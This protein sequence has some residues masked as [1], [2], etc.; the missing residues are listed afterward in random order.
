MHKNRLDKMEKMRYY[1][2]EYGRIL[3]ICGSV[4]KGA[5]KHDGGRKE[6]FPLSTVRTVLCAEKN[7]K[8]RG[9]Q[10]NKRKWLSA[11]LALCMI[12]GMVPFTFSA[13]ADETGSAEYYVMYGGTG[14]GLT[15]ENP[16][17]SL[18]SAINAI[19]NSGLGA[20]T[21]YVIDAEDAFTATVGENKVAHHFVSY[22]IYSDKVRYTATVT[23]KGA[24][25]MANSHIALSP[26]WG[27]N[28]ET[29]LGGPTVFEDITIFR[30]RGSDNGINANGYALTIGENVSFQKTKTDLA[31]ASAKWDGTLMDT[32]L[33]IKPGANYPSGIVE[34]GAGDVVVINSNTEGMENRVDLPA[35]SD[36]RTYANDTTIYVNKAD[37]GIKFNVGGKNK[38]GTSAVYSKNLNLVFGNIGAVQVV[39]ADNGNI[40]DV[41]KVKGGFQVIIPASVSY[42]DTTD[43]Y[44]TADGGKWLMKTEGA[45]VLDVTET[46]GAFSVASGTVYAYNG[47]NKV[48]YNTAST[49]TVPAGEWNVTADK[50][51]ATANLPAGTAKWVD[52]G[53]GTLTAQPDK[54]LNELYVMYGGTGDG[55]T[56]ET[57]LGSIA[58]AIATINV[59]G[60][61]TGTIYVIDAEDAFT[62]T[63]GEN[64]VAHHFVSWPT[65]DK[66]V[67]HTAVITVKG[68]DGMEGS[69]LA[70][71]PKWGDNSEAYLGGPTVFE[72][73][74]LFRT[75]YYDKSFNANGY[76]MTYG[77][78][79]AFAGPTKDLVNADNKWDGTL[80]P[81]SY[82]IILGANY[83][84]SSLKHGKGGTVTI[85]AASAG[86]TDPTTVDLPAWSDGR[87]YDSL[88]LVVKSEKNGVKI[89][90]G[91]KYK[92]TS[93]V[94]NGNVNIV[95]TDTPAINIVKAASDITDTV[96]IKGGFQVIAPEATTVTNTA[97]SYLTADAGMWYIKT[98]D[99]IT[100]NKTETAGTFTS[101]AVVYAYREGGTTIYYGTTLTL[102]AGEW[103]VVSTLD[104]AKAGN[105]TPDAPSPLQNFKDWKD[106]GNGKVTAV[107]ETQAVNGIYYVMYGGT[108]D[109]TT[110]EKPMGSI[111]AAVAA[112]EADI[113]IDEGTVY[114]TNNPAYA[115]NYLPAGEKYHKY[116]TWTQPAAHEKL[117]HVIGTEAN[118]SSVIASTNCGTA[119]DIVLA[120]PTHFSNIT[121]TRMRSV[122]EGM[123]TAGFDVTIDD[124]V[125][126]MGTNKDFYGQ[127]IPSGTSL[128]SA[129]NNKFIKFGSGRGDAA[130][131]GG[132]TEIHAKEAIYMESDWKG[133]TYTDD[134]T[135]A[136]ETSGNSFEMLMA[137]NTDKHSNYKKNLNFVFGNVSAVTLKGNNGTATVAKDFQVI[138]PQ[139]VSVTLPS[140]VTVLGDTYDLA[141]ETNGLIDVTDV[142]GVYNVI[143]DG[144]VIATDV[145]DSAVTY[146]SDNGVLTV[147]AGSYI[148]KAFTDDSKIVTAIFD[149]NYATV[150]GLRGQSILLP[151]LEDRLLE[152]FKGWKLDDSDT[153]YAGGTKYPLTDETPEELYFTSVWGLHE[154][155]AAV[156]VDAAN[157][158]DNND[159]SSAS[160]AFAT[161]NAGFAALNAKTESTK[162][163]VIV[164]NYGFT[165]SL[166]KNDSEIIIM[167]DGSGNSVFDMISDYIEA[168]GPVA[169]ENIV[170]QSST[171]AG[172][173]YFATNG[174]ALTIGKGV[175]GG[176]KIMPLRF[177]QYNG[178][179][180][181][182]TA[183][184]LSGSY[185]TIDL[186]PYYNEN[187]ARHTVTDAD[188]IVDGGSVKAFNLFAD[189][190]NDVQAGNDYA[191]HIRFTV[192]SGS[193]GKIEF[194]TAATRG[195]RLKSTFADD[196]VFQ[197]L[198]NNGI[199][200]S[201]TGVS[202]SCNNV[203]IVSA[204]N[205]KGSMLE[206]TETDGVYKVI[207]DKS[208]VAY[209]NN[210]AVAVSSQGYITIPKGSTDVKFVDK[211]DYMYIDGKIT[212]YENVNDFDLADIEPD[213]VD[214]KVFIGWKKD[215]VAA[216]K[217][218]DYVIGDVL[219]AEYVDVDTTD[220]T[221]DFYI[222][223]AQIRKGTAD[224]E[225]G[226]RFVIEKKNSIADKLPEIVEFGSLILPTDLTRGHDMKY[227]EALYNEYAKAL[228]AGV[229]VTSWTSGSWSS[230]QGP[231]AVPAVNLFKETDDAVWY[232]VCVTGIDETKYDRFYS[233]KGYIRFNDLNGI[234]RVAYSE[235]YQTSLA[236]V[237]M[238]AVDAGE[239]DESITHVVDYY[240]NGRKTAYMAENYDNRTDLKTAKGNAL[241]TWQETEGSANLEGITNKDFY[242]LKNGI[243]IREVEYD[244]SNG[245]DRKPVEIVQLGDTHL[246]YVN[247][248]D[249]Q[250]QS[251]CILATYKGRSWNRSGA[252]APIINKIMEY[253]SFYDQTVVTGD[254]MDYFSWGCAEMV[255][256]LIVD[257]D[258]SILFTV[259][260]HEPAIHMQNVEHVCN[261]DD[262]LDAVHARLATFW[263]NDTKYDSK[264]ITNE[265]GIEMAMLVVVDN[266][267][268]YYQ[269]EE[270]YTGLKNDIEIARAKNIPILMFQHCPISTRGGAETDYYSW[271]YNA[272]DISGFTDN[273]IDLGKREAGSTGRDLDT[274]VY[275][276]IVDNADVVRG[277]FCGDYHNYMY[278]EIKGTD[279]DG[280]VKMIPQY[281]STANA[282]GGCAVKITIK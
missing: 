238:A 106:D 65:V 35:W 115:G 264:I 78:N 252:S 64:M 140:T 261:T 69:H 97:G 169:F 58:E 270:I 98:A 81:M 240:N 234:E 274:R 114:V 129:Y 257:K 233:V 269:W 19:E 89:G 88:D 51:T 13:Y 77:E 190:Y 46:A 197:L 206:Y 1:Y 67:Y 92:G 248:K 230:T 151:T 189:S 138:H 175:T 44:L 260:N 145:N 210:K 247:D 263:P 180:T 282:Y 200:T 126:L 276:L 22:P 12:I 166:P 209:Q 211:I 157:G 265:D 227:G 178:N 82:R 49:L 224:V 266:Q 278:T 254:I 255:Q 37:N 168:R 176:S 235:Y 153:V 50:E 23:I 43:S 244:L 100:V 159:G 10:M 141:T 70:T 219:T 184:I 85:T 179:M 250:E 34:Q 201:V 268:H 48:Y 53:N 83:P 99:G 116:L 76:D 226:L 14:D 3:P 16:M 174:N 202:E 251:T 103:H 231:S 155:T 123:S 143:G 249:W 237:A 20:G 243:T 279:D 128:V 183:K 5:K 232:T 191:G 57:P 109:G 95:A 228:P 246:N 253:A 273:K 139:G 241:Q 105:G 28:N 158:N 199:K 242:Q 156:Y 256:K 146:V 26:K 136:V 2:L 107:F 275:K 7:F 102:P 86:A 15:R 72:D 111:K 181:Q 198:T 225:Q 213:M 68:A 193:V 152:E 36:G 185:N 272:G 132:R 113:T 29:Y 177:G 124:T 96:K 4:R 110:P 121:L 31:S 61:E 165:G 208:A 212:F 162:K 130:G 186:G 66:V 93:C 125:R 215:G 142:S 214:G 205:V 27:D 144:L 131:K 38:G 52:D 11:L 194:G 171:S 218:A 217:V 39:K 80:V 41:V 122:D 8:K 161:L 118:S 55:E 192:N 182:K 160:N 112:I 117:I 222:V 167:G 60:A 18:K 150:N 84:A 73:I 196:A 220:E 119:G 154:D 24:D 40:T 120:G 9:N 280:N 148:V 134:V 204:E 135:L 33:T 75:R 45:D 221:G 133:G 267:A 17:G 137:P 195:E 163:L 236:K 56:R 91:G 188:I 173:K 6:L 63:V 47:G 101:E 32:E 59:S 229:N 172:G 62:A 271:F 277:L 42:T 164:G 203:W 281:V 104:E 262:S 87:T 170:M 207:G 30:T 108:G 79:V 239:T 25:G 54:V 21:I 71:C 94:V 90:V 127:N 74:T 223:G 187:G 245:T 258:P 259:G 149:V 216:A 147:P